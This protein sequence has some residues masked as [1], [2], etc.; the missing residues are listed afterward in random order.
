VAVSVEG[1]IRQTGQARPEVIERSGT[2]RPEARFR[3]TPADYLTATEGALTHFTLDLPAPIQLAAN[4][5]ANPRCSFASSTDLL[6]IPAALTPRRFSLRVKRKD[7]AVCA[8]CIFK[9]Q[10]LW[11]R[12]GVSSSPHFGRRVDVGYFIVLEDKDFQERKSKIEKCRMNI[13]EIQERLK[14]LVSRI[15][16]HSQS[17]PNDRKFPTAS[18]R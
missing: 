3:V 6:H 11:L 13:S 16:Q 12:S 14:K 5:A 10:R 9:N 1:K 8:R 4:N 15:I 2:V 17:S 7:G 18:S